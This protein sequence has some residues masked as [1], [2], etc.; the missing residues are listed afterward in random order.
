MPKMDLAAFDG[1]FAPAVR[2]REVR[3]APWYR[4]RDYFVGQWLDVSVWKS[5]VSLL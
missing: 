2:P 3:L 5:A 1:S 4:S